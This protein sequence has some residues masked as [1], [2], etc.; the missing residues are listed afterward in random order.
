MEKKKKSELMRGLFPPEFDVTP[1]SMLHAKNNGTNITRL[2]ESRAMRLRDHTWNGEREHIKR[3]IQSPTLNIRKWTALKSSGLDR[4]EDVGGLTD[5]TA[6]VIAG[7]NASSLD[8]YRDADLV[9]DFTSVTTY[10]NITERLYA[11]LV[12]ATYAA[13][14]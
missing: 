9:K 13:G 4:G 1:P 3:P 2:S 8:Q 12:F 11:R 7:Y 5:C 10:T 14:R 6:A